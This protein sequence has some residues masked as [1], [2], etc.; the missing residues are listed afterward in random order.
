MVLSD[1]IS[2][3]VVTLEICTGQEKYD[4]VT[5]V[6]LTTPNSALVEA[7]YSGSQVVKLSNKKKGFLFNVYG[8]DAQNKRY[9]WKNIS[10]ETVSY[11]NVSLYELKTNTFNKMG[12]SVDRRN[13]TRIKV[14]LP[15]AAITKKDLLSTDIIINDIS[16]SGI[17]F[18]SSKQLIDIINR[19]LV[20]EFKETIHKTNYLIK[21]ECKPIREIK[22][23]SG[24]LYGCIIMSKD[25]NVLSYISL[26]KTIADRIIANSLLKEKE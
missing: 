17:S 23:E 19:P 4:F 7:L 26:K 6:Y 13:D 11:G 10:C 8:C 20:I 14:D 1:F 5:K 16:N 2:N 25:K 22:Q 9:G 18:Y 24:Y 21:I 15:G 3:D 12:I